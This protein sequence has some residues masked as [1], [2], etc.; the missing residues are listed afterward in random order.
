[1]DAVQASL[2]EIEAAAQG[3]LG[4]HILDTA[5]GQEYGYRSDERCM[6]LS[7]FKLVASALVLHRTDRGLDSLDRRI[8][9]TRKD[10]VDWSPVTER[11]VDGPGLTLGELCEA[12]MTTSDNTAA[13]LILASYGG[14]PALTAYLRELGDATSRLDRIETELNVRHADGVSDTTTPRAMLQTMQKLVLGEDLSPRSRERLQ[15]WMLANT[16]GGKRLKAG[17]PPDWRIGD[18]TGTSRTDANDIG[19][20]WPP[21]HAPILVTAYLSDS[22]ASSAGRDAAIAAVGRLACELAA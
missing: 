21:K 14:P 18:K 4:V 9:Y 8:P 19:V 1:M 3:R 13:N 16:T 20:I 6:L 7:S 11:H 2:R 12:T 17:L 10:L 5:T 22:R 15:H